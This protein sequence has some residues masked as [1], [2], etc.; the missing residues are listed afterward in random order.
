PVVLLTSSVPFETVE[1]PVYVLA[2]VSERVPA[3]VF[4]T[5]PE[6][7]IAPPNVEL[8]NRLNASVAL[9]AMLPDREP[10]VPPLPTCSVPPLIVVPPVCVAVPGSVSVPLNSFS[11]APP[12]LIEP[13]NVVL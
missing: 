5:A 9:L 1:P 6:P 11:S 13:G 2:V 12:P 3:P 4:T 10:V 8:S 7:L